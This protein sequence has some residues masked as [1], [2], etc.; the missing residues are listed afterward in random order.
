[1]EGSLFSEE[2]IYNTYINLTPSGHSQRYLTLES[3]KEFIE[4]FYGEIPFGNE[5]MNGTL[6]ETEI[7]DL[8]DDLKGNNECGA[9]FQYIRISLS[10][11]ID[12]C[13]ILAKEELEELEELVRDV[14]EGIIVEDIYEYCKIGSY[15]IFGIFIN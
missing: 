8:S 1:M 3:F 14:N 6:T 4:N 2:D 9:P 15:Y 13:L 5:L 10:Q 7:Q 11:D 12:K